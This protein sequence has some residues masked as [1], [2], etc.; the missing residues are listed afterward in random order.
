MPKY[1]R[2]DIGLFTLAGCTLSTLLLAPQ[3]PW[4]SP[5]VYPLTLGLSAVWTLWRGM[6]LD[7]ALAHRRA[8]QRSLVWQLDPA[9]LARAARGPWWRR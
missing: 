9:D 6:A 8:W 7:R 2:L 3:T 4:L 5:D 1:P